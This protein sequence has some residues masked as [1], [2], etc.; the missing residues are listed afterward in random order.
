MGGGGG[1]RL[2]VPSSPYRVGLCSQ[3]LIAI[4]YRRGERSGRSEGSTTSH[5]PRKA[6]Q[7][8]WIGKES[9]GECWVCPCERERLAPPRDS[10]SNQPGK[11]LG[12]T[13][14]H[15]SLAQLGRSLETHPAA[16]LAFCL[17]LGQVGE[18]LIGELGGVH[19][20]SRRYICGHTHEMP[21]VRG[22]LGQGQV[23]RG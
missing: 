6:L 2:T 11:P 15:D 16:R 4:V 18:K 9:G 13:S 19:A 5:N 10:P 23:V 21:R 20:L 7:G 8:R 3:L 12:L 22:G 17:G 1:G 14:R